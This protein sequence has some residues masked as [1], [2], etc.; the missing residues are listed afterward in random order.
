MSIL[1]CA[2]SH[3]IYIK[4]IYICTD[5]YIYIK[6]IYLECNSEI[7]LTFWW[8]AVFISDAPAR[9]HGGLLESA[10]WVVFF[11]LHG[12]MKSLK[13]LFHPDSTV[14]QQPGEREMFLA[15]LSGCAWFG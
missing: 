15:E 13:H 5:S 10:G 1:V 14:L 3:V 12:F 4:Y 7:Y 8:V 9:Q 6:I 11:Y 2:H